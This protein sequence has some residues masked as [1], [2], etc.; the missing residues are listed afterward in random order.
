MQ[1][2]VVDG[3]CTKTSVTDSQPTFGVPSSA[4]YETSEY[5]GVARAKNLG[6]LVNEYYDVEYRQG[7]Y[8]SSYAPV[9]GDT[10]VPVLIS[11]LTVKPDLTMEL[12]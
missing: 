9:T 12:Y 6:V 3:K 5:L 10:C 4:K 7:I 11:E 8:L 2:E 1:Y